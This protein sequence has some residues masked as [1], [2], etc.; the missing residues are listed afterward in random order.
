MATTC[1]LTGLADSLEQ[2]VAWGNAVLQA[3][4]PTGAVPADFL[5]VLE[6]VGEAI[7]DEV[8]GW[9]KRP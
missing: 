8:S 1:E 5:D 6:D 3:G 7:G 2:Q 4:E 9:G